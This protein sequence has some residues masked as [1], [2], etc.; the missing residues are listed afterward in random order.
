MKK[1]VTIEW[2]CQVCK[3]THFHKREA[4]KC[5]KQP[6]LN[7]HGL[8]IGDWFTVLPD[9][10]PLSGLKV[11]LKSIEVNQTDHHAI[12]ETKRNGAVYGFFKNQIKPA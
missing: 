11:Q 9:Y 4:V 2:Q 3:A 6:V 5:E 8:K 1:I 7:H 10:G 12:Y